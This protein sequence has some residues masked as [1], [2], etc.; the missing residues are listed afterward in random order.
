MRPYTRL[1][2]VRYVCL[3]PCTRY[4]CPYCE[5]DLFLCTVCRCA[6]AELLTS[7]PGFPLSPEV[8]NAIV[9]G[10]VVDLLYWQLLR[11]H[12]PKLFW[13]ELRRRR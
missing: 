3:R 10:Q 1:E 7:C 13:K 9:D 2:H 6:E 12:D 5:G 8:M 4:N 11:K